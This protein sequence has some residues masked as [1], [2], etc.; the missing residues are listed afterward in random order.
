MFI[1]VQL[2][3]M[4]PFLPISIGQSSFGMRF[5]SFYCSVQH[6]PMSSVSIPTGLA[7]CNIFKYWRH[8]IPHKSSFSTLFP[9]LSRFFT[10]FF[11]SFTTSHQRKCSKKTAAV[12][13][14]SSTF[15]CNPREMYFA[16]NIL[17]LTHW[18]AKQHANSWTKIATIWFKSLLSKFHF[19]IKYS[20]CSRKK[21]CKNTMKI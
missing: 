21:T 14:K 15:I 19:K 20:I 3:G 10:H 9:S 1:L 6:F 5:H 12:F 8:L 2:F 17:T 18:I 7:R 13:N 4:L 11:L 16:L